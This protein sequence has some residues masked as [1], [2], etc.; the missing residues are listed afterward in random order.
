ME[1][2]QKYIQ[3]VPEEVLING[4]TP[5]LS[6]F[7]RNYKNLFPKEEVK[8]SFKFYVYEDSNLDLLEK[9]LMENQTLRTIDG[10]STREV[11]INERYG[12][13]LKRDVGLQRE[14]WGEREIKIAEEYSPLSRNFAL[15]ELILMKSLRDISKNG[16]LAT[17]TTRGENRKVI[18]PEPI[19]VVENEKGGRYYV[20]RYIENGVSYATKIDPLL[21]K[22]IET[23]FEVFEVQINKRKVEKELRRWMENHWVNWY[24]ASVVFSLF[25]LL[26]PIDH[27]LTKVGIRN[28]EDF[29]NYLASNNFDVAIDLE[30]ATIATYY[31]DS[32][33][34]EPIRP[35]HREINLKRLMS[36]GGVNVLE[37]FRKLNSKEKLRG[38]IAFKLSSPFLYLLDIFDRK[39]A[40]KYT[41]LLSKWATEGS[42][43]RKKRIWKKIESEGEEGLLRKI[44]KL[45]EE[46]IEYKSCL[47]LD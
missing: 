36:F 33:T 34:L 3:N 20:E 25:Q 43:K 12:V 30:L 24:Y 39:K 21:T 6:Y 27:T 11:K 35:F 26:N 18:V 17:Y 14:G 28:N 40:G 29:S 31:S 45:Y 47:R 10:K 1:K 13:V 38:F 44:E 2:I 5:I 37:K 23:F 22:L 8:G 4:K 16:I 15:K 7:R 9:I 32:R 41:R 42:E 46:R 19:G